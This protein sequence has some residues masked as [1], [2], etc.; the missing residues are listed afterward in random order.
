M[1]ES[2]LPPRIRELICQGAWIALHPTLEWLEELDEATLTNVSAGTEEPAL[3]AAVSAS[4]RTSLIHFAT[5]HLR[6]PGAPVAAYLGPE[7]LRMARILMRRDA[8]ASVLDVYR[9]GQLIALQRWTDI[10]FELAA[11]PHELHELL[12][13]ISRSAREFVDATVGAIAKQMKSEHSEL[14]QSAQLER[15]RIVGVLLGG[16]AMS[17]KRAEEALG[18]PLSG[19]HTAAIVW[20][21]E[22]DGES[23]LLDSAAEELTRAVRCPRS[24]TVTASQTT[25]WMWLNDVAAFDRD[26]VCQLFDNSSSVRIAI[27]GTAREVE[28]FRR[29]HRNALA[30][31]HMMVRLQSP[32]QIASFDDIH[33]IALLTQRPNR[34]QVFI[35]DT[36]GAL[37]SASSVLRDT[38]LT[39]INLHCNAVRAAQQLY[40]HRNTLLGRLEA[41]QRL[42]PRPLEG[43]TVRVAVALE[44]LQWS[45]NRGEDHGRE[46]G[47]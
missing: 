27:G 29:S 21:S 19:S 25:R 46:N 15:R 23:H 33:M 10:V 44:A 35:D 8:I 17:R 3:A 42:L 30:A 2:Q 37:A 47:S 26:A 7:P 11:E 13:L 40:I 22:F 12:K 9:A 31:Q 41:A 36:L 28:G 14:A 38:L 20:C 6:N 16:G 39:Y 5:A 24:L 32:Q 34:A 18:Y 45:G 4:N 43:N 1:N